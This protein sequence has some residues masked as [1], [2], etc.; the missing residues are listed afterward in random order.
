MHLQANRSLQY[1][2]LSEVPRDVATCL[3]ACLDPDKWCPEV[4]ARE[5]L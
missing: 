2:Y 5:G 1:H 3:G 4:F